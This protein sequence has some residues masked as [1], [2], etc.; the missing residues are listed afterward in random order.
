MELVLCKNTLKNVTPFYFYSKLPT[1]LSHL[2]NLYH[3]YHYIF[4]LPIDYHWPYCF[5]LILV[6]CT[7]RFAEC[8]SFR[9]SETTLL[10]ISDFVSLLYSSRISLRI[11][12]R[13][14]FTFCSSNV[15]VGLQFQEKEYKPI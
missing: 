7:E 13:T 5:I 4:R 1:R 2:L 14:F 15:S 10:A 11:P 9:I 12:C 6:N 8:N 3:F